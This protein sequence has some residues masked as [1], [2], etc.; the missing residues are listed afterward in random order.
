MK[1]VAIITDNYGGISFEEAEKLGIKILSMPFFF[2]EECLYEGVSIN[3]EEFFERLN[4]GEHVS[5][6]QPTPAPL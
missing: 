1:K 3:R 5:T 4:S 6:T 2:G